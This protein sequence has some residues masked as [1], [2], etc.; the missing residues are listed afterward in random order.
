MDHWPFEPQKISVSYQYELKKWNSMPNQVQTT[1]NVSISLFYGYLNKNNK[2]RQID[3]PLC[4]FTSL[5]FSGENITLFTALFTF[6]SGFMLIH[7]PCDILVTLLI[8]IFHWMKG[9][10]NK[11]AVIFIHISP[12]NRTAS[13]ARNSVV[14]YCCF[15][16]LLVSL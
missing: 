3:R 13:T 15:Q 14:L 12:S 2:K 9:T 16:Y 5:Y 6:S 7:A 4:W 1:K 8:T 10:C 11:W